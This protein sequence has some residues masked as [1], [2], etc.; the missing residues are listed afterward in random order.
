MKYI[1][2]IKNYNWVY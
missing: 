1:I 2:E